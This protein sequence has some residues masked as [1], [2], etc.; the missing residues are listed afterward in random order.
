MTGTVKMRAVQSRTASQSP[1]RKAL[2]PGDTYDAT[3]QQA[4]D[5]TQR[6]FGVREAAK[7]AG[8]A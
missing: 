3:P 8:K 6:G 7:S 2:K 5:D 4:R 1:T